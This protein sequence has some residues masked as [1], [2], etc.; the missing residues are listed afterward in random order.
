MEN[1]EAKLKAMKTFITVIAQQGK[2]RDGESMLQPVAYLSSENEKLVYEKGGQ[3]EKVRFPITTAVRGY[4][5][6]ADSVRILAIRN[7]SDEN[8]M[9]NARTFFEPEM[10]KI[11]IEKEIPEGNFKLE[12]LDVDTF[13]G[14]DANIRLFEEL[15]N[16]IGNNERLH[17]CITFGTKPLPMI[18]F[19]AM[20]YAYKVRVNTG[21]ECILYGN[22]YA[23]GAVKPEIYDM[24][25]LF[26]TNSLFLSL[27]ELGE[28]DP[29]A[30][31]REL[32]EIEVED[33]ER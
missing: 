6:E 23:G 25:S 28:E 13:L 32:R 30:K 33:K 15:L 17:A 27:A 19:A 4:V 20:N 18:L 24:T 2:N 12:Y 11:R 7:T 8:L 9:Y 16:R 1:K 5:S 10:E 3:V 22:L 21:I 14:M 26:Y 29:V 31:L